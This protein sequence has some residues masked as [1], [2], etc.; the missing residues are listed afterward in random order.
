MN[1]YIKLYN[2]DIDQNRLFNFIQ[3]KLVNQTI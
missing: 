2:V 1:L 3:K